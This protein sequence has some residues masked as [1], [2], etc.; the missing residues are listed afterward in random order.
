MTAT[1]TLAATSN[2]VA[3]ATS[4]PVAG[5]TDRA[6]QAV[7]R[8]AEKATPALERASSSAHRTIDKVA[9]AAAPVADWATE[10]TRQIGVK[11][12]EFA[13]TC[14]GYIRARPLVSV[15]GALAIGYLAGRLLR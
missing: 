10:N 3:G 4:N 5:M 14:N 7:D 6:H 8:M 15:A 9:E 1:D 11:T 12:S 13:E 2:P